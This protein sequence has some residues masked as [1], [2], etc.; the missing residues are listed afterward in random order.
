MTEIR[1]M[2][3]QSLF[4][5][6]GPVLRSAQLREIGVCSK[7]IRDLL[8][9]EYI[10]R[11]KEGYYSWQ[12]QMADLSDSQIAIAVIPNAT[13]YFLSAAELYGLTTIIPEVIHIAVPNLG[14]APKPPYFPPVEI[15]QFK[16]PLFHLGRTQISMNSAVLPIYDR[17][18]TVCDIVKRRDETGD[19]IA[20]EVIRNYMRGEKKIQ[21]LYEYAGK[22]RIQQK[23]HPYVEA[24]L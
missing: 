20:L 11:L 4:E 17:E 13:L 22:M 1:R 15:T 12:N 14:K 21:R 6:K 9:K 7:D 16:A 19:D 18:R 3:I 2:Q 10:V 5:N 8:E 23:L 24:L